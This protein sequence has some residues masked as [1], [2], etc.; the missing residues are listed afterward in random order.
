VAPVDVPSL[1]K[2]AARTEL[3]LRQELLIG[4][5]SGKLIEEQIEFLLRATAVLVPRIPSFRLVLVGGNPDAREAI[6]R[7]SKELGVRDA[8]RLAGF[9]PPAKVRLYQAAA[10]VLLLHMTR[11]TSTWEYATPAKAYDYMA[12]ERP[13]VSTSFPMFGEVFGPPSARAVEVADHDHE[14][15][16]AAVA[17]VLGHPDAFEGMAQRAAVWIRTRNW[18][19]RAAS[20]LATL[21]TDG[22]QAQPA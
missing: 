9:V 17:K 12:A 20:V 3:G 5:Y 10:D 16:A 13:I 2:A 19:D 6:R 14:Q 22:R 1:S 21:E 11:S 8:V 4:C 18:R 7:R 15:F